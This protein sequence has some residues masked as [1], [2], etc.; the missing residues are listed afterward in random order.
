MLLLLR[1][2]QLSQIRPTLNRRQ[3]F[4]PSLQDQSGTRAKA[5]LFYSLKPLVFWSLRKILLLKPML[6]T[7][8][9]VYNVYILCVRVCFIGFDGLPMF[10]CCWFVNVQCIFFFILFYIKKQMCSFFVVACV[11]KADHCAL[12]CF[13]WIYCF[14]WTWQVGVATVF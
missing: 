3:A 13:L 4:Q 12:Q 10:Y 11:N 1:P 14:S 7:V 9:M 8:V 2:R 5:F 6:K